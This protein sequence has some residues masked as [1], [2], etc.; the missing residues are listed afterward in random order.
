MLTLENLSTVQAKSPLR[1]LNARFEAG[2]IYT[3]L[4]RTGAGKTELLRTLI[5]LDAVASGTIKLDGTDLSHVPIRNREMAMVYQQFINY[6]HLSVLDNVA[7]PLR[8]QGVGR[9]EAASRAE[10]ALQL[11]GLADFAD[12][13]PLA[14]SGGQQQRVALARAIVKKARILLMDE[15]L[16]N[17]DYKLREELRVEIPKIFEA[18]GSIFVYA[19]TEPEEALLLGG[20]VATLWEGRITQFGPTPSVY[21]QP[22]DATTARVFSDPPMNF[23]QITKTGNQ[24]A[25][26]DG[27]TAPATGQIA[28]L[29]D[30]RYTAGFRPN[31]LEIMRHAAEAIEFKAT[32]GVTELTGSETFVHLDHH[33]ER[34]VG[35]IHGV[36][37]LSLGEEL[38]V[39]LDPRHIY[40]FGEDGNL[41]APAAYALAA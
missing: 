30:G 13:R 35:L 20:H 32:L 7:F 39:W 22:V 3:I 11:V 23:L 33:G 29:A 1:D 25:F 10:E 28:T 19:T 34:W 36:H 31:H 38:S 26:G 2:R 9:A 4:G 15:P 18:S 40:I 16:A 37:H 6:P 41:V 21:R 12:R 17:L 5:G 27:Q 8:R 24:I 14:L